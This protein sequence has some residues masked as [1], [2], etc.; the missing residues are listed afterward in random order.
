MILFLFYI[1]VLSLTFEEWPGIYLAVY[2]AELVVGAEYTIVHHS[3]SSVECRGCS[4]RVILFV[5][6]RLTCSCSPKG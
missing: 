4:D 2:S 3:L 6:L 1:H 5:L